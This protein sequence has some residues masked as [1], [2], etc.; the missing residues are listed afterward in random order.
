MKL[1]RYLSLILLL[2]YAS[3]DVR[4]E[5]G[6]YSFRSL[7]VND[8][9]SQNTVQAILQDRLGFMWF[10]TKDGLNRYDGIEIRKIAPREE[11][12]GNDN[13]TALCEDAAGNIWIGTT[14]G[15]YIYNPETEREERFRAKIPQQETI[16]NSILQIAAAPDSTI[17]IMTR[18]SG[19]LRF[20]P[21]TGR[22]IRRQK[23]DGRSLMQGGSICF[24]NG[25]TYI[26]I[27]DGNLYASDLEL[28]SLT[29]LFDPD[30][31]LPFEGKHIYKL[32]PAS[33]N[34]LCVC[35]SNGLFEISLTTR[36]IRKMENSNSD[37]RRSDFTHDILFTKD[38]E[39]W[40]A[41]ECGLLVIDGELRIKEQILGHV[42]DPNALHDAAIYALYKD[43]EEGIWIGTYFGGVHYCP[44]G[45]N[46]IR[47][48]YAHSDDDPVG[49]RI[50]EIVADSTGSL[51]IGR[52]DIGLM[53]FDPRTQ[54]IEPISNPILSGNIHGLCVD[55][56]DL[57]I[58]S[59]DRY[60][61]LVRMNLH[62]RQMKSY[63]SAGIEIYSIRKTHDGTLWLGTTSG[64]K[65]Y[66]RTE[67]RFVEDPAVREFIHHLYEDKSGHL[68]I[69]TMY[70]G[71]YRYN[72]ATRRCD[73]YR[74][75]ERDTTSLAA[76][77]A[78]SVFEDS[79]SQIWVTTQDGGL[80]RYVPDKGGTFVR[81]H[82]R[83]PYNTVYR[84][85]ED[86]DGLFW[87][88]TN[89]GLLHFDP[90]TGAC[91]VFTTVDGLPC[92]QFNYSSSCKT[93]DG[94]LYFGSIDGFVAFDPSELKPDDR[95]FPIRFTAFMLHNARMDAGADYSPLPRSITLL[96][97]IELDPDENSFTL[98][99]T[100]L[101]YRSP[102]EARMRYRLEGLDTRWH[103][104]RNNT[105]TC[106]NLPYRTLRLVVQG[107]RSDGEPSGAER[108]LTIRI[109]PPLYRSTAAYVF[110]LLLLLG[111]IVLLYT[112]FNRRALRQRKNAIEQIERQKE[113]ELYVAKFDFF[114]NI[115]HEIRT[116]LSL[117]RG[118]LEDLRSR[119]RK[120]NDDE[121][122]EDI[123]VMEQ[124]TDR[125]M[126][127]INQLLD[128][129]KA[130]KG[131]FRISPVECDIRAVVKSVY[132][133]FGI[134]A[135]QK[136]LKLTA[137]FPD[138]AVSAAIDREALTKIVSNL[139]SNAIKYAGTFARLEL[140]VDQAEPCFRITV[141]NDGVIV[142]LEQRERI[143]Q[144]LV[145]YRDGKHEIAGTGIGLALARSLT[146]LHHGQLV[147]DESPEVNRFVLTIPIIHGK[148]QAE[149]T[150]P[151][152]D[153]DFAEEA[154]EP[155]Q[156]PDRTARPAILVVEDDPAMRTFIAR[157]LSAAY[158]ITTADDGL[159]ALEIL[160][161]GKSFELIL[162]DVMMPRM[163]GFEFCRR[164][165]SELKFSHIPLILLTAK[166][167][168]TSKV[169][170]LGIG[171]DAYVEKPFSPE[172]LQASIATLLANRERVRRHFLES[173]YTK[174]SVLVRTPVD[175]TF[176]EQLNRYIREHMADTDLSVE[177]MAAAV[178]LSSSTLFRKLKEITGTGPNE[179]LRLE[180]LKRAV[181]LLQQ[182][183]EP[184]AQISVMVGFR[185][186]G[187]FSACFKKQFGITPREFIEG[188]GNR[189]VETLSEQ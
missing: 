91:K 165:K 143:F 182:N 155:A 183:K 99:V 71:L 27:G 94:R 132:S 46:R 40:V 130:E 6:H 105:I 175:K 35:T 137:S 100:A 187:Y 114:T 164:V 70:D 179:Y 57:W 87:I 55:G 104:V 14:A 44:A 159:Q 29:P 181:E 150:T 9:L 88:S 180:R 136:Q 85:E 176:L 168:T 93:P 39:A 123:E 34:R 59:Y 78:L 152:A 133:R 5:S 146:E 54:H 43:R 45:R 98:Q 118:P 73:H 84:I 1:R 110:Y 115:A 108:V 89:R 121:I 102:H 177:H 42:A 47:S 167:D 65:R 127:L 156:T 138:E 72:P 38:D 17:L 131:G 76:N 24:C 56:N 166:I 4:A 18:N 95:A 188:G 75:D 21:A 62:T 109:R 116:P 140:S 169:Q 178:C 79:R 64:L 158:D 23:I 153:T 81:Y 162:S 172:Y 22:L 97:R 83:I 113:R 3:L 77:S 13:V 15:V 33:Y 125:L 151:P 82:D 129:H 103:D 112:L 117:I 66:D 126:S 30:R 11:I 96:D 86:A 36:R 119:T 32:V 157:Q 61:G 107:V 68:W 26:D 12:P 25:E 184:I 69:S 174:S 28:S 163:D 139:L 120:L 128:F 53:R 20:D 149:Q 185:S 48:Y 141:T 122:H 51:W 50:R 186:S 135:R 10:A 171:A 160:Q 7:D 111:M 16:D 31:P 63:P 8:G 92:N 148:P 80:C 134:L 19:L 106:S 124:N 142:P 144:P 147:M 60:K 52:E 58:G 74:Y 67:D 2:A 90:E 145:Q 49:Q 173:P 41:S 189:S 101:T 154:A 161:G 37:D 170:G